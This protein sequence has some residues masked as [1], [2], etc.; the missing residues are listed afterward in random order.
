MIIG[1]K[2]TALIRCGVKVAVRSEAPTERNYTADCQ[3]KVGWETMRR[4]DSAGRID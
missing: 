2:S 1:T 3:T 4:D